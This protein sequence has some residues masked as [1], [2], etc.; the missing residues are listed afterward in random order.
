MRPAAAFAAAGRSLEDPTMS[1]DA[2]PA[3]LTGATGDLTPDELDEPLVTAERRAM[4]DDTH[5]VAVTGGMH[6]ET[7]RHRADRGT[8]ESGA[9]PDHPGGGGYGTDHGLA[10]DDPAYAMNE[11]SGPPASTPPGDEI[12]GEVRIDPQEDRL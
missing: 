3:A 11:A 12:A 10:G 2:R 5:P 8:S 4:E 9:G 1:D 7:E 6:R